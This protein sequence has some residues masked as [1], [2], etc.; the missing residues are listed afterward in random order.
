MGFF[1]PPA[2][3][4]GREHGEVI[5]SRPL[6][7][8]AALEEAARNELVLYRSEAVD[9]TPIAVSGVIALPQGEPPTGGFPIVSWAHGTLGLADEG[10]PTRDGEDIARSLPEHHL[11]NQAPHALLN[12]FLARG[13]AVAMTDYEGLGTPGVHP[14]LLGQSEARGVLDIAR[15]ARGLHPEISE[16]LA[17]V[18]HSQGGQAALFAAHHAPE[19]TPELDLRAVVALAPASHVTASV[20][21]GAKAAVTF[22]G[23]A[24][25]PLLLTGAVVG[26]RAGATSRGTPI[27]P[28][29]VLTD[30]A[31]KLFGD[32]DKTRVE[33]SRPD[34]WGGILGT[35]QFRGDIV[36]TPNDHQREFL[37]QLDLTNPA[38]KIPAPIR[39]AHAQPDTR[40]AI[41]G[42]NT[43]VGE[44]G[45]LGNDV[46][47]RIHP[48]TS[49]R[50][51][52]GPHFGVLDTDST[53][54]TA[55]L[56]QHL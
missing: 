56:G 31:F 9:G 33:L 27:D 47:Y 39:I 13:W 5:W 32:S 8:P 35:D 21:Q 44:L 41:A 20:L 24:F 22:P 23:F 48:K 30:E 46:T 14:Y 55:W 12:A 40:V 34:S 16:R 4:A 15:A 10:A 18:G 25:T 45:A 3:L 54:M 36:N 28:A 51:G 19:W 2:P 29:Q 52:L 38:L 11:I 37:R 26:S 53:D 1:V 6:A 17:V 42:T 43:L 50:A 7:G 49:D